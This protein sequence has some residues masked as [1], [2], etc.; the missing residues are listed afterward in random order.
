MPRRSPLLLV[1]AVS[2]G[3]TGFLAYEAWDAAHRRRWDALRTLREYAAFAAWEINI[4]VKEAMYS[5]LIWIFSPI[6]PA[7]PLLPGERLPDAEVLASTLKPA[8]RCDPDAPPSTFRV[9]LPSGRVSTAGPAL[10]AAVAAWIRDTLPSHAAAKHTRDLTFSGIWGD[11]G[12][13]RRGI[14]YTVKWDADNRQRAAYGTEFCLAQIGRSSIEKILATGHVLPPAITHGLPNDSLISVVVRDGLGRSIATSRVRY[15]SAFGGGHVLDAFG[16]IDTEVTF[17]PDI[18]ELVFP[19]GFPRSNLP[20]ALASLA[21]ALTLVVVGTMQLRRE[22]E[23]QRLRTDFIASVSHELR[24]PLAQLRMF[25][26]TLL[27]GRVRSEEERTRSLE[28][29]DQEARRLSHLVENILQ[30]SRAERRAIA[31]TRSRQALAPLLRDTVEMF[32][33]MARARRVQLTSAFADG[34]VADVDA[35]ALRQILLNLLDNAVKY[36]PAGQVVHVALRRVG[37]SALLSVEDEGPGIPATDRVRIWKAFQRLERD[38]NS[39][40]AGSGI[41]L[42]VVCE[43]VLGHGGRAWVETPESG[44]GARFVIELPLEG[45]AA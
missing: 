20:L 38:V 39:A 28:I 42:S 33:P 36:G 31:L 3:L 24:T 2:L 37:A 15:E 13:S 7:A 18:A 4:S 25:A 10:P 12:G 35:G 40:V 22:D 1:L 21:L 17:R 29:I 43:L 23:L 34:L 8:Y 27:L 45:Q 6:N 14:V 30:F 5:Q 9:D 41:G 11:V 19:G 16:D 32:Q 44:K 26:E